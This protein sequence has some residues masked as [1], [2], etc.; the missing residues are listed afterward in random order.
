VVFDGASLREVPIFLKKAEESG[1]EVTEQSVRY[2]ALPSETVSFVEQR[3]IGKPVA[4]KLLPQRQELRERGVT[5]FYFSDAIAS[6]NVRVDEG[7]SLLLWS[8]FP[9]VTYKDSESRFTRHFTGMQPLYDAAWKNTVMQAPRERRILVT[10]DHGYIFFGAGFDSTR[11]NNACALLD[12]HRNRKFAQN[13]ELPDPRKM[14][15]LQ[16][17]S[18]ERLAMVRGRLK[19]QPQGP[20]ANFAYRH[21]GLS[22]M[23]MLVPWIVLKRK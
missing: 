17:F 7:N 12:Q 8:A 16:V 15:D 23:E 11:P 22:L 10:S 18:E 1:F 19:N 3:L 21:G 13:E 6:Q 9:D 20:S 5:S 2:A 14:K 4:P